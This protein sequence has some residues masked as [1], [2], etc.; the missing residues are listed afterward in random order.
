MVCGRNAWSGPHDSTRRPVIPEAALL[1]MMRLGSSKVAQAL[2]SIL[3][4]LV[5]RI[6]AI[7]V[8]P[9]GTRIWSVPHSTVLYTLPAI[10]TKRVSDEG[11]NME[12]LVLHIIP[13][14]GVRHVI[15]SFVFTIIYQY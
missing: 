5:H 9:G 10:S 4:S 3:T 12:A 6:V 11:K 14:Y 13:S 1:R 8:S 2:N 7:A 15:V